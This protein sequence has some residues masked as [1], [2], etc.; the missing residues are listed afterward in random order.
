MGERRVLEGLVLRAHP[1]DPLAHLAEGQHLLDR[2][3]AQR[4]QQQA[5]VLAQAAEPG[6]RVEREAEQHVARGGDDVLEREL[7][8]VEAVGLAHELLVARDRGMARGVV[9]VDQPRGA[10]RLAVAP[11]E[12]GRRHGPGIGQQVVVEP[13]P[14]LGVVRHVREHV[15]GADRDPA[16]RHVLRVHELDRVDRLAVGEQH[17][18]GEPVEVGP[19]H[20]AHPRAVNHGAARET[21]AR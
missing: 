12:A 5:K 19:R 15:R 10:R 16:L 1:L 14:A 18:A 13:H 6:A 8:R 7:G 9:L 21:S 3:L 17:G 4:R 2:T 11:L 20:E